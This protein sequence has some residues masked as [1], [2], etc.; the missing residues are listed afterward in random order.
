MLFKT[1]PAV[2]LVLDI[3]MDKQVRRAYAVTV[4]RMATS[5]ETL[6]SDSNNGIE[7]AKSGKL[8]EKEQM[9]TASRLQLPTTCLFQSPS[10]EY[11]CG[12]GQGQGQKYQQTARASSRHSFLQT[13]LSLQHRRNPGT[14]I[15]SDS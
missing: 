11:H 12:Q 10:S 14:H 4:E 6:E 1:P 15:Q 13:F 2:V 3:D 5:L 9:P 7:R 8:G